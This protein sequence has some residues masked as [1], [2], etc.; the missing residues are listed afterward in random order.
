MGAYYA[1]ILKQSL[2]QY[3]QIITTLLSCS[4][5]SRKARNSLAVVTKSI[6]NDL[7]S[8]GAGSGV[9]QMWV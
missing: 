7:I 4:S 6:Q 5:P 2:E 1:Y 9:P 3:M 8:E